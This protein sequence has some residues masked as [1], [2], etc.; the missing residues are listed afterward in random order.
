MKSGDT[1]MEIHRFPQHKSPILINNI[2]I[3]KIIVSYIF[4][5][6]YKDGKKSPL[7]IYCFQTWVC[8]EQILMELY[9]YIYN[10]Y[11]IYIYI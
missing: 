1:G 8:I 10:I 2:D 3:K 5:I 11:I 6:G 4:F 7:Y 9:I